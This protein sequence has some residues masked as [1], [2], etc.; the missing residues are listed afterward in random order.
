MAFHGLIDQ[1]ISTIT[2]VQSRGRR[3]IRTDAATEIRPATI[4]EAR[5][6]A[7]DAYEPAARSR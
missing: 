6:R 4:P 1:P 3:P 2:V 7:V 5:M